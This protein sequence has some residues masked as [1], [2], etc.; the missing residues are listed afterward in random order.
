MMD[1]DSQDKKKTTKGCPIK[2]EHP[3]E[4]TKTDHQHQNQSITSLQEH[5]PKLSQTPRPLSRM[6]TNT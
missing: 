1:I 2:P 5:K 3:K 6:T 4:N